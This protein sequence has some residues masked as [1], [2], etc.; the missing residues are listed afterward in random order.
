LRGHMRLASSVP[1]ELIPCAFVWLDPGITTCRKRLE[2]V[3]EQ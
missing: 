1:G 2:N 3:A